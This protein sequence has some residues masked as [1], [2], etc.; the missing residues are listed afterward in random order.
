MDDEGDADDFLNGEFEVVTLLL[1]AL[2]SLLDDRL[3][4]QRLVLQ[5]LDGDNAD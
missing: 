1:H 4:F 3:S 5:Q 2:C